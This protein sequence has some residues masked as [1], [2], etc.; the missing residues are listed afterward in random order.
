ML[1]FG[2]GFWVECLCVRINWVLWK[3]LCILFTRNSVEGDQCWDSHFWSPCGFWMEMN[4]CWFNRFL[5]YRFC[6]WKIYNGY[7]GR[8]CICRF[9][10]TELGTK[11]SGID[12]PFQFSQFIWDLSQFCVWMIKIGKRNLVELIYKKYAMSICVCGLVNVYVE[13]RLSAYDGP[14]S[15]Q[16]MNPLFNRYGLFPSSHKVVHGFN[17]DGKQWAWY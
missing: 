14:I 1:A 16:L 12:F 3:E 13:M 17:A 5:N 7:W 8:R 11:I 10:P 15:N 4:P 2:N 6:S 9:F